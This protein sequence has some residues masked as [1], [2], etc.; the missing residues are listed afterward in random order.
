VTFSVRRHLAAC[1][2]D[3]YS[4]VVLRLR[5]GFR[6]FRTLYPLCLSLTPVMPWML[7]L[8]PSPGARLPRL[9]SVAVSGVVSGPPPVHRGPV[10]FHVGVAAAGPDVFV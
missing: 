9:T 5:P 4:I 7:S 6:Q 3:A 10:L 8:Q 2:R 1:V